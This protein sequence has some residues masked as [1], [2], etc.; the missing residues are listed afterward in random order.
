MSETG[1]PI[2]FTALKISAERSYR[3][4]KATFRLLHLMEFFGTMEKHLPILPAK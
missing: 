1:D 4:K 2:T 3:I